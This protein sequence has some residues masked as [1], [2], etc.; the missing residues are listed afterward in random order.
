MYTVH[1]QKN[2]AL[3]LRP[4]KKYTA[5]V[6]AVP[7]TDREA[8]LA[9]ALDRVRSG[10]LADLSWRA[11][12][13]EIGIAPNALYHHFA[14]RAQLESA[15]SEQAAQRLH[16]A[17]RREMK[18]LPSSPQTSAAD[19]TRALTTAYLRFAQREPHLYAAMLS[20]PCSTDEPNPEH[21]ALWSLVVSTAAALHGDAKAEASAMSLWSLLHGAVALQQAGALGAVPVAESIEFGLETWMRGI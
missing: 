10:G 13:A 3:P 9:A 2:D 5:K 12:A 15:L 19:R 11:L 21:T 6:P 16:A 17:I 18:R 8:I 20:G 14:T 4:Q 1:N 7:K